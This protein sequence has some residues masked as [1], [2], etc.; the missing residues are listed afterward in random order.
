MTTALPS[1][2]S[3][4][5]IG[6]GAMGCS[7]IYHLAQAG[8]SDCVLLER[9]QLT[10]GTT[11]HSAAQIRALR[12]THNMTELI[13]YSIKLYSTLQ[14]E[15]KQNVGWI[16]KGSLSIATNEERLIHI[17]RQAA[18]AKLFQV[19]AYPISVGE[20]LERWPHMNV[21]DVIGAVWSPQD[22][23]VSPTDLCA[24]LMRGAKMR[25]AKIFENTAVTAIL[26]KD[27][28]IYGV[29]THQGLIKCD[30]IALC[31][32]LW[33][34]NI[35]HM[36][37]VDVPVWGCEHFYL[38]T[39]PIDGI[40][41][42]LP[43]LSDHDQHLY[44]RDDSGG[45]LVGCFEP[46]GK[47]IS[48]EK[49]GEDFAFQLLPE[50]WDHFEPMLINA[51]HRLPLLHSAEIKMLLNGPESFTPD[52]AF[53]LGESA[54]TKGLYLGCG[55]NSVGIASSGGGGMAL[56]HHIIHAEPPFDLHEVDP[57]RFAPEWSSI[58]HLSARV[59]EILG[60]HY[61]ISHPYA[62]FATARN[63]KLSP[64]HHEWRQE[65]A[66]FTQIYAHERALYF[67]QNRPH[68][69]SFMRP[70][71]FEN[72]KRE[73]QHTHNK[74]SLF[75]QSS[76]GKI[77]LYGKDACKLLNYL[78]CNNV[79]CQVGAAVYSG[80]LN[81]NGGFLSDL[82]VMRMRPD[83]YILSLGSNAIKRD[84]Y[85]I[86]HHIKNDMDV[87]MED[88]TDAFARLALM[89]PDSIGIM[90]KLQ[91]HAI[92]KLPFYR[93]V[94]SKID[95]IDV[96]AVRLSYVGEMGWEL[97]CARQEASKLYRLITA[98]GD[99]K[100]AGLLA[101][102]SMRIEKKFLAFG[103]ELDSEMNPYAAGM[104]FMVDMDK[105]FIGRAALR[106]LK[107]K[108]HS[109]HIVALKLNDKSVHLSGSEPLYF[110][111]KAIGKTTSVAYGFRV[112]APIALAV[113]NSNN[114]RGGCPQ[115]VAVDV[116]GDFY[117]AQCSCKALY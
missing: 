68:V 65:K 103:H 95:S 36:A 41:G 5:V 40:V 37:N 13:K 83:E 44:I 107:D 24:A 116:A 73:A 25:G 94:N 46:M 47:A 15:T 1:H 96:H 104:P 69:A 63:I 76:L 78:C 26:T 34:K 114:N 89:G 111:G 84:F 81:K 112:D 19:E 110:D 72:V 62:P 82:I 16:N 92:L 52:G 60:K 55:M 51:L 23:R 7:T 97:S 30:A 21:S 28:K 102:T 91:A 59:P 54:E 38:L 87:K 39:K 74:V 3:V 77:R 80:M 79:A 105:D 17:K 85:Y 99:V 98:C 108:P 115:T 32:G 75:D 27:N 8:I 14:E 18:L 64:L 31:A 66:Y 4:V 50:D 100:P 90:E 86:H 88:I 6:G 106:E 48:A 117:A 43:T 109:Q 53:L 70:H 2:A 10:S 22:G 93:H 42:N 12:S 58:A 101:Q 71:W 61:S 113:I 57:K 33:S 9:N 56:A 45:L 49:L 29:E 67:Q 20:A 11:W 35:A